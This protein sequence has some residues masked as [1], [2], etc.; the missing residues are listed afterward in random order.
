MCFVCRGS[1]IREQ[2]RPELHQIKEQAPE[3]I[4]C[5]LFL[6]SSMAA[7]SLFGIIVV[8]VHSF[9]RKLSLQCKQ[10]R[11][12]FP[13]LPFPVFTT[14]NR[15]FDSPSSSKTSTTKKP[16]NTVNVNGVRRVYDQ[17]KARKSNRSGGQR[18]LTLN[19]FSS[20][21]HFRQHQV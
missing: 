4:D 11:P 15:F 16:S 2:N 17:G 7:E 10:S 9:V 12:T 1:E 20:L 13:F 19:D 3:A 5:N 8:V 6:L 18:W 21:A 14:R